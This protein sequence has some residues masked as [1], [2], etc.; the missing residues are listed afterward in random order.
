MAI[1]SQRG[2]VVLNLLLL[3]IDVCVAD[4]L[5]TLQRYR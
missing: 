4:F 2:A 5:V 3:K 1:I